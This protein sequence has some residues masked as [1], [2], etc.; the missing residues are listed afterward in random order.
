M[1]LRYGRGG[2]ER[3]VVR[4]EAGLGTGVG[5][6]QVHGVATAVC[7]L[8]IGCAGAGSAGDQSLAHET[9]AHPSPTVGVPA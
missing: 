1:T 9:C 5:A 7:R 8:Q 3:V 6:R 4:A 2:Y